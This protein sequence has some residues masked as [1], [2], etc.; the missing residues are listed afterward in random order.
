MTPL[1]RAAPNVTRPEEKLTAVH[2]TKN[3]SQAA[4]PTAVDRS[5]LLLIPAA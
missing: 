5:R 4:M 3:G 1:T 2:R